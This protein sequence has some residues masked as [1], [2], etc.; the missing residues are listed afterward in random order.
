MFGC[1]YFLMIEGWTKWLVFQIHLWLI[2]NSKQL[3]LGKNAMV[4]NGV[5]HYPKI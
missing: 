5:K 4:L 1:W 3:I 2:L